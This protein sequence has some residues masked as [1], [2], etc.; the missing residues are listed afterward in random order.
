MSWF[1]SSDDPD[2]DVLIERAT[3]ELIP[4]GDIDFTTALEIS[5]AIRSKRVASKVAMRALKRRLLA[6][7]NP[8]EQHSALKLID[9][10]IKNGGEHF[11]EDIASKEFIDPLVGMVHDKSLNERVRNYL[12]ELIQ[13]WSIMFSTHPNLSYVNTAYK[14]LQDEGYSF[15]QITDYVDSSLIESK[16]APE[17]EDSDACM[18]CSKLFSFINRKHHCRSCG[19][20][21]CG[22][23]SQNSCE[24]P[25]L[26]ITIPVRVCDN[27]YKEHMDKIQKAKPKETHKKGEDED[28]DLKR[29]IA[30]S[31]EESGDQAEAPLPPPPEYTDEDEAM[32]A[33]IAASLADMK[34]DEVQ[35]SQPIVTAEPEQPQNNFYSNMLPTEDTQAYTGAPSYD[36]QSPQRA[37]PPPS[38]SSYAQPPP[39]QRSSTSF[40]PP[41][42]D[43]SVDENN[44][45]LLSRLLD[46]YKT[47][48][49][50][51]AQD[52]TAA[53]VVNSLQQ[54]KPR[55]E[56][57]LARE[58]KEL[59]HYQEAYSKLFAISKVYD[60]VIQTRLRQQ[61]Q[62][63]QRFQQEYP[64]WQQPG[65]V[66]P[67]YTP[68]VTGQYTG[69]SAQSTS[70]SP[71]ITGQSAQVTGQSTGQ[72]TA[73][74]VQSPV[75]YA[76][77]PDKSSFNYTSHPSEPPSQAEDAEVGAIQYAPVPESPVVTSTI[78]DSPVVAPAP[79]P[80]PVNL[81]D[82]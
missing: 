21:F 17:W 41:Q 19:G 76:S 57:E 1:S 74:G 55:I 29:A 42:Q 23:H 47:G 37:P 54:T 38:S 78:P 46:S 43:L 14:K 34:A 8:N 70:Q 75:Q 53:G 13:E 72:S 10:C 7:K 52:P 51:I 26:G 5:D 71:H 35:N 44:I 39:L 50:H 28:E 82:L 27:C 16:V 9:F 36:Y 18:T 3:S 32:K 20:V 67:S 81:I 15:P 2:L 68:Q 11:L 77:V 66:S 62:L 31:L 64:P 40:V 56:Y 6:T 79:V 24:L 60:D 65:Q 73:N 48:Q 80:E 22:E 30:L 63:Q 25:E 45:V 69:Q 4:N 12:L 59:E 49:G 58:K 33:A 61:Q